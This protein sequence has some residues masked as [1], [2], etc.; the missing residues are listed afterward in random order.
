MIQYTVRCDIVPGKEEDLDQFLSERCKSFW[1]NQSG[2][3]SFHVYGDALVGWPE[4]TIM[5]ELEDL[6][7]LQHVLDSSER[8]QLRREFQSYTTDVQSQILEQ[9]I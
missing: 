2:V 1:L 4:R 9:M 7:S 8:K 6:A 3:K 5:I